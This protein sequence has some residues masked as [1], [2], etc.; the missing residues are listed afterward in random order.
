MKKVYPLLSMLLCMT[1]AS[2]G[3]SDVP[4]NL[5]KNQMR[6]TLTSNDAKYYN[7]ESLSSVKVNG[8]NVTVTPTNGSA[9]DQYNSNVNRI[10]FAKAQSDAENGDINSPIGAIQ[11]TEA[12]GWL[13]TAYAKWNIYEGAASYNVYCNDKKIDQQLVRLYPTYVR[14]DVVGLAA[15]TYTL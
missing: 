12:K 8:A 4:M 13:E 9:A 3:N 7:T 15:G 14:A 10:A 2:A 5:A 1:G 11:I 6:V